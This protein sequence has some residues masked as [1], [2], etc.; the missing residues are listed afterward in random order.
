MVFRL[1]SEGMSR[2]NFNHQV[3]FSLVFLHKTMIFIIDLDSFMIL[4]W[5]YTVF[6]GLRVL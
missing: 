3:M 2:L 4:L 6:D 1:K 5:F